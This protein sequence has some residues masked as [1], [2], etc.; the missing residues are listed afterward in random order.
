MSATDQR[1]W[2]FTRLMF[3]DEPS[4]ESNGSTFTLEPAVT[5]IN[6]P[7]QAKRVAQRHGLVFTDLVLVET[8]PDG[9]ELNHWAHRVEGAAA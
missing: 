1:A 5:R 2:A 7:E 4:L 6:S 3:S 9:T 8:R